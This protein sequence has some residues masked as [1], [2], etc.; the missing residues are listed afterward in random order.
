MLILS[1]IWCFY[2]ITF[3]IYD[4]SQK[5]AFPLGV[6]FFLFSIFCTIILVFTRS[7]LYRKYTLPVSILISL[8]MCLL[9]LASVSKSPVLSPASDFA[10]CIE[11]LML[12][13]TVIPL[14]LYLCVIMGS[15]YSIFFEILGTGFALPVRIF[16]HVCVHLIA[17]HILIMT[18]VRMR[19]TFMKVGQSL[20]VRRQMEMEKQL[21]EKMIHSVSK[22]SI[23]VK[24]FTF[25][26]VTYLIIQV[27]PPKVADWLMEEANIEGHHSGSDINSLFRPFNMNCMKVRTIITKFFLLN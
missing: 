7:P 20:L 13:Y 2:L 1:L 25:H 3:G 4:K 12:I 18:N 24:I 26:L 6:I 27:M 22:M 11:I 15:L 14:P 17:L 9:S 10:I 19:G 16:S 21:K 8:S 5:D 23:H